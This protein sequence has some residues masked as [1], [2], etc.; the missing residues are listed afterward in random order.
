MKLKRKTKRL[1]IMN[2]MT[3]R[4]W[5]EKDIPDFS[6]SEWESICT[7]CGHCCVV[8]LQ[9]EDS[10]EVFYTNVACQH[11]DS[12][13]CLCKEYNKRCVLVPTCLKITAKNI[14]E[15]TWMPDNCAY[16][17]LNETGELPNWHPLITG[18]P[19][20]DKYSLKGKTVSELDINEDDIED[21]I[22]EDDFDD[23]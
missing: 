19:L 12:E 4:F 14:D 1:C 16:R 18:E 13:K 8:K 6:D 20:E 11:F 10:D 22:I 15:I 9:D 17:I 21:Y 7:N 2:M 3:N 23:K 5:E